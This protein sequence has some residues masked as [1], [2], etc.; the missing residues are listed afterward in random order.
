MP[1]RLISSDDPPALTNGSGMPLVG[2]MPST[3]LRLMNACTAIIPVSPIA[4]NDPNRSGAR[5][6]T[7][8]PRHVITA[9]AIRMTVAPMRP[10]SSAITA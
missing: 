1:T 8:N 6:A 10:I 5:A 9:K 4:S 3:T 7:R 2:T